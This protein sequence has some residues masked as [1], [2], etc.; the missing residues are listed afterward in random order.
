M[1]PRSRDDGSA[2]LQI[3]GSPNYASSLSRKWWRGD[4]ARTGA[5]SKPTPA[6]YLR[7]EVFQVE[8]FQLVAGLDAA[9]RKANLDT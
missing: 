8:H 5:A 6:P 7:R 2:K 3:Y 4:R 9:V 1:P